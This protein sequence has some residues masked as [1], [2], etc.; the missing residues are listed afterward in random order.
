MDSGDASGD[1]QDSSASFDSETDL[2]YPEAEVMFQ[3][4]G[5]VVEVGGA[6]ATQSQAF[7]FTIARQS[8]PGAHTR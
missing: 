2:S 3:G 6:F 1:A 4:S 7:H 5:V 8:T